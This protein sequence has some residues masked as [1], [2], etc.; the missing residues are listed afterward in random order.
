L[1]IFADTFAI[2]LAWRT[3]TLAFNTG[4]PTGTQSPTATTVVDIHF[5]IHTTAIASVGC[6]GWAV[7][8]T[9]ASIA[10][11]SRF[12]LIATCSTVVFI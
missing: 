8:I 3:G 7:I 5:D 2:V 6:A 9:L 10:D 1:E 11:L 4:F 12:T